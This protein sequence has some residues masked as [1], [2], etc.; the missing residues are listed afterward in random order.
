MTDET[1]KQEEVLAGGVL[2][3]VGAVSNWKTYVIYALLGLVAIEGIYIIWQRGNVA[4]A[5]LV[6][7]NSEEKVKDM[8]LARDLAQANEA[9]CRVNFEDQNRKIEEAG[10]RYNKL[11]SEMLDLATDIANGKY[12]KPAND[13]RNQITPK[14][15]IETLD[16]L[17]R[18]FP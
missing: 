18:N 6:A 5:E 13:V 7:R 12:Y 10:K 3:V 16:F 17:K 14:T 9:T 15:C 4:A 11:Q 8:K 1:P 2:S